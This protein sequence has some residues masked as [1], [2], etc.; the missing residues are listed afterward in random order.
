MARALRLETSYKYFQERNGVLIL[1]LPKDVQG[2]VAQEVSSRLNDQLTGIVD[3]GGNK[4]IIDM[5]EVEKATPPVIELVLSAIQTGSKLSLRNATVA[6]DAIKAECR[7]YEETQT[8]LFAKTC[9]EALTLL[10]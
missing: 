6:S 7:S 2:S 3:A 5:S 8:W 10:K 1:K 4:L 9:D